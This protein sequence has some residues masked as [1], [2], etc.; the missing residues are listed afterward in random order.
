MLLKQL[1]NTLR[2][3]RLCESQLFMDRRY[4][5]QSGLIAS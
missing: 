1:F 4:L 3:L 2:A 5:G